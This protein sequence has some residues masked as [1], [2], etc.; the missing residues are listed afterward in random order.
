L[1]L[2]LADGHVLIEGVPG[3]AKTLLAKIIA[4]HNFGRFF[5]DS[6]HADLMPSDILGNS[7]SI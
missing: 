7:V 1:Q 6:V 3:I 4:R 5:E 2:I